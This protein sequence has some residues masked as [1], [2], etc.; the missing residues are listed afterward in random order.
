MKFL[1]KLFLAGLILLSINSCRD[2][3]RHIAETTI[4]ASEDVVSNW[5]QVEIPKYGE[6]WEPGSQHLIKWITNS[7]ITN[8]NIDLYKKGTR[9]YKLFSNIQNTGELLWH[10][11]SDIIRSNHYQLRISNYN[12][13]NQEV[14]SEVFYIKPL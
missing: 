1:G 9:I 6:T 3:G 4:N 12:N 14:F 10:I 2:H 7:E 13:G 5:L 8:V 11:P